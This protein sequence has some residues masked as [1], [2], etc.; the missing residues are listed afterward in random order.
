M[1]K[2]KIEDLKVKLEALRAQPEDNEISI[3]MIK[4]IC[5]LAYTLHRSDPEQAEDYASKALVLAERAGF[6]KGIVE[7][8][9]L[10]GTS[11]W[12]R[13]D[14]DRALEC[15]TRSLKICKETGDSKGIASC[16]SN[17][18]NIHRVKGEYERALVCHIKA[19]KIKEEISDKPGIAKSYNNV[20]I[21]Y[22]EWRECDKAL[23]YYFKALR[24]FEEL[25]DPQG[26]ALSYNNI[27][28]ILESQGDYIRAFKHYYKSL[29][30]K[31]E[32]GD[33]RGIADSYMNIGTLHE[34]QKE[35]KPA[36]EYCLK[37]LDIYE[38]I[39]DKRGIADS[40]NKIGRI[41][42]SLMQYESALVSLL[43][44]LAFAQKIGTKDYELDSY[45]YLSDLYQAMREF[46]LALAYHRKYSDLRENIFSDNATEKIAQMQV[47]YET[48]KKEKEAEIYRGIF[49]NTVIGMYRI[50]PAGR[51]LMANSALVRMLGY[52]SFDELT[53]CNL[54]DIL[55]DSEHQYLDFSENYD[56]EEVVIGF[57]SVW[58]KR[59]GTSLCIRESSRT[60]LDESGNVMYLEGTV[61]DITEKKK[62][63]EELRKLKK[64]ESVGTLAGGIAHD[65]NNIL[66]GL[67]GN[68]SI[69][70]TNLSDDH[71]SFKSLEKAEIS[72]NRAIRL[73]G[74]LLTF[75][76][77]GEPLREDFNLGE[78]VREVTGF[79]LSG[80]NVKPVFNQV[81]DLWI[82]EADKGQMQQVFSNLIINA[83][84]AMPDGGHLYITLENA[85]V[86]KNE[87]PNLNPGK[88]VKTTVRDEGTGI[89]QE[90]LDRIFD[91]YFTTKQAGSG[92]GLAT[93]YSIISK[94]GGFI[95]ADSELGRG[96][97]FTL[98]FHASESRR[99]QKKKRSVVE[100]SI[101]DRTVRVLVMDDDEIIRRVSSEML[102]NC[103]FTA[104]S[105]AD[106]KEALE[107]YITAENNANPFDIVI[108][109]LTVPGGMGGKDAVT[110]LLTF[111][112][113]AKVIVS[114]GYS[115]DPV[116]ASYPNY[117]FQGRLTKPYRM[118][119]LKSEIIRIMEIE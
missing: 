18:G 83:D 48:E 20:G 104:D 82:I 103:G 56:G 91:P 87:V 16:Y 1:T 41:Q 7:S 66:T 84:Q 32:I 78:L 102:R 71:P 30:I 61:E 34:Q 63:E 47:K 113:E 28:V 27:G 117:G 69:A 85:D 19:L 58:L 118:K 37:A 21:I 79:G 9:M 94:H 11:Y 93:V 75:A 76:K 70:K 36:L 74:Q 31:E 26:I 24:L 89:D 14:Y 62:T 112:P 80:S 59:D 108:M 119:D 55:F 86:S 39:G 8:H 44:G 53:Q 22:D 105:A 92:L 101:P 15:Y 33:K 114:S 72:M 107:K 111:D 17:I 106:G 25:E 52:S 95:N 110:E 90:N 5:D 77:G 116:L 81:E 68:I 57:E 60:V 99:L 4:V 46:E 10:I 73:T 54:H 29:S 40:N 51:I 109:D 64:L 35:Y 3:E 98:Y 13:G 42:T 43:K 6:Q 100:S 38:V 23:D 50:T 88:Y 115:M 97:T 67:F 49:K 12:A 45:Q 2:D 96:T 65:F